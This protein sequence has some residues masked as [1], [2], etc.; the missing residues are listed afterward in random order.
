VTH[1]R[2]QSPDD[3]FSTTLQEWK[4]VLLRGKASRDMDK[5]WA[6]H[7]KEMRGVE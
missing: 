6:A 5:Y 3:K 2:A 7:L 4:N 1:H